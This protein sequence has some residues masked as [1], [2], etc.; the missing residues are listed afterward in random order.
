MPEFQN[1]YVREPGNRK[2]SF[3]VTWV[4][5]Q[6][7]NLC[8]NYAIQ[9]KQMSDISEK[10]EKLV[11]KMWFSF[12]LAK[13]LKDRHF[14]VGRSKTFKLST[15]TCFGVSFKKNVLSSLLLFLSV[16]YQDD[17]SDSGRNEIA[18]STARNFNNSW[19]LYVKFSETINV[20]LNIWLIE[21]WKC[22]MFLFLK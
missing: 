22:Q 17:L 2:H 21:N 10:S 16:C 19:L 18:S 5:Y 1:M 14:V 3:F 12:N 20:C 15:S 11:I 6:L 4:F 7:T 9:L 8:S 13:N